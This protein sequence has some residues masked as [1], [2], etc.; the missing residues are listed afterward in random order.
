MGIVFIGIFLFAAGL[1]TLRAF[2]VREGKAV[3]LALTTLL[4]GVQFVQILSFIV[5]GAFLFGTLEH[6]VISALLVGATVH[7]FATHKSMQY[8]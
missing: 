6:F 8:I 3:P 7:N 5:N 1:M 4:V 2:R